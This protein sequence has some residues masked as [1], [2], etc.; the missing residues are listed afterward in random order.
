[1]VKIKVCVCVSILLR[2]DRRPRLKEIK[3][4]HICLSPQLCVTCSRVLKSFA[5]HSPSQSGMARDFC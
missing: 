1:M 2:D 5:G 4:A 3:F